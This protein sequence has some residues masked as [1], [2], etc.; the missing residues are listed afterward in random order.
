MKR[1]L[2]IGMT[3]IVAG[4]WVSPARAGDVD[5]TKNRDSHIRVWNTFLGSRYGDPTYDGT[6]PAGHRLRQSEGWFTDLSVEQDPVAAAQ[7]NTTTGL[8]AVTGD[9]GSYT[10]PALETAVAMLAGD[11]RIGVSDFASPQ[12]DIFVTFDLDDYVLGGGHALPIGASLFAMGGEIPGMP[13]VTVGLTPFE[14]SAST[15][16]TTEMAY[17]GPLEVIGEMGLRAPAPG[18]ISLLGLGA[19]VLLRR[20]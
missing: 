5:I 7:F 6:L 9:P 3:V 14:F 12:S 16:W 20:R 19:V 17:T 10:M 2:L 13:G 11:S 8:A 4:A 1:T 15:G 18:A